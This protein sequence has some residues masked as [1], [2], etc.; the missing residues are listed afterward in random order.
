MK[1][2]FAVW[3]SIFLAALFVIPSSAIVPDGYNNSGEWNDSAFYPL[4]SSSEQSG[5]SAEYADL[6]VQ[7]SDG[8][9][10]C[11]LIQVI[12]PMFSEAKSG[13]R[14]SVGG[15]G[16][17]LAVNG[18]TNYPN[19]KY[20]SHCNNPVKDNGYVL[21]AV[22]TLAEPI[23]DKISLSVTVIDGNGAASKRTTAEIDGG[24][25]ENTDSEETNKP[26]KTTV[27]KTEKVTSEKTTRPK[28]TKAKAS[29]SKTETQKDTESKK[30]NKSSPRKTVGRKSKN[31]GNNDYNFIG[32]ETA[33]I[34]NESSTEQDI[35]LDLSE[36]NIENAGKYKIAAGILLF[37]I[38][39]AGAV[40][41]IV[42]KVHKKSEH[43]EQKLDEK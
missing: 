29:K 4:F 24:A 39:T 19:V 37:L 10:V 40:V 21:E 30:S 26:L 8:Y 31:S 34:G 43:T 6:Q 5:C 16:Y 38:F 28:S 23:G 7:L 15:R 11:I 3:V 42:P 32:E 2:C 13:V 41:M 18:A 35:A 36:G 25:Y 12:D 33:P 9:T 1:K 14:V 22:I 20:S 17:I 27:P